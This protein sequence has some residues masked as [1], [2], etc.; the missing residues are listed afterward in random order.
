L[1]SKTKRSTRPQ[2]LPFVSSCSQT[3]PSC[4]RRSR[5]MR[6][7]NRGLFR[8]YPLFVSPVYLTNLEATSKSFGTSPTSHTAILSSSLSI[9]SSS[10]SKLLSPLI[11]H[12]ISLSRRNDPTPTRGSQLPRAASLVVSSLGFIHDLRAGLLEP[13]V[14]RGVPLDMDQYSRLF[15]TSRIPTDASLRNSFFPEFHSFY[16]L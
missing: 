10:W 12:F 5:N 14:V 15:G 3:V 7:I 6:K 4:R 13:D 2:R 8:S 11:L 16:V 1:L 9:H